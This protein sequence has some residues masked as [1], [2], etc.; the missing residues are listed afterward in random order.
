MT[1]LINEAARELAWFEGADVNLEN[2]VYQLA[3]VLDV[4]SDHVQGVAD[5]TASFDFCA[6]RV[7]ELA[8]KF[9]N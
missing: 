3:K 9:K 2:A 7:L 1:A 5:V 4:Y 8:P 6:R